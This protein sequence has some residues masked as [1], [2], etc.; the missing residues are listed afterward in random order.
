MT[1]PVYE[2]PEAEDGPTGDGLADDGRPVLEGAGDGS[3]PVEDIEAVS[4]AESEALAEAAETGEAVEVVAQRSEQGEVWAQPDGTLEGRSFV[5]PQW[6]R[7]DG[8]WVR[9]DTTLREADGVVVPVAST[10]DVEFSA[11]GDG[12]LVRIDRMGRVVELTWPE[13][14][15]SPG[16]D[17]DTATYSE[18]L[19]G[20]DLQMTAT[21]DGY[22]SY[23]VVKTP[24]AATSPELAEIRFSLETQGLDVSETEDGG[25][26]ARDQG[27]AGVVFA[28]PPAAM[29]DTVAEEPDQAGGESA[30]ATSLRTS[31]SGAGSADTAADAA[32]EHGD[33]DTF[34]E[35]GV[36][37]SAERDRL[38]LIPDQGLLNDPE[39]TFPVVIDPQWHTPK[40]GAWASPNKSYPDNMGWKFNGKS[41]QGLGTCTGWSDCPGGSTYR[42]MYQFDVSRFKGTRI[43]SAEFVVKNTH[44]AVCSNHRV[45]LWRVGAINSSNTSW[46]KTSNSTF[47]KEL[48]AHDSFH[49]GGNQSTCN[50]A[51]DAE[52]GIRDTVQ[53]FAD[54]RWGRL[55]LGMRAYSETNKSYWKKFSRNG[56]V[57]VKYNRAPNRI[58]ATQ[59]SMNPGGSCAKSGDAP[60]IRQIDKLVASQATD[61]DGDRLQVRFTITD[62]NNNQVWTSGLVPSSSKANGSAFSVQVPK[63]E[64]PENKLLR[65]AVRVWDGHDTSKWSYAD[66]GWRCHFVYDTSRPKEPTIT[67]ARWP[68]SDPE[69]PEDP[70]LD[71][72]G[73]SGGF[74][75]STTSGDVVKYRYE[76]NAQP[77]GSSREVTAAQAGFHL[78]PSEPGVYTI[79]AQALDAAGN[80]STTATYQVR[81][82]SGR[83]PVSMWGFDGA[84]ADSPLTLSGDAHV[85]SMPAGERV[86]GDALLLD[87]AGDSG[88]AP[89]SER[90]ATTYSFA[91]EAWAYLD[92]KTPGQAVVVSQAGP[93][94]M[95]YK[96]YYTGS[97]DG[98][99]DRWAF[100][101]YTSDLA[102]IGVG[103]DVPVR[104]GRWTHLVGVHNSMTNQL[105]IYVDGV[106][107][108]PRS[109]SDPVSELGPVTIGAGRYSAT[110]NPT[111]FWPGRVDGVNLYD[112]MVPVGEAAALAYA[113][114]SVAARWSFEPTTVDPTASP[115]TVASEVDTTGGQG[116]SLTLSA[117]AGLN[118]EWWVDEQALV[119]DGVD[120]Y[121]ATSSVPLDTSNSF[122]LTG[123]AQA[124]GEL[125]GSATVAA[126]NG[127]SESAVLVEAEPGIPDAEGEPAGVTWRLI[128]RDADGS[129]AT[130]AEAVDTSELS[131]TDWTHLAVVYDAARRTARLVVNGN[132]ADVNPMIENVDV[133][134]ASASVSVGRG[135]SAGAWGGYWPGQVDDVWLFNGTLSDAQINQFLHTQFGM[136]TEVPGGAE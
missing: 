41:T 36:E 85:A 57:R 119:L 50:S 76:V 22:A 48:I 122:T 116:P 23:F 118:Q 68:A 125:D 111:S 99:S 30:E 135:R 127:S 71:G 45:D 66:S 90:V 107:S 67:S 110:A 72:V 92:T 124:A 134:S 69:N 9:V 74:D 43:L 40:A 112:R 6:T 106:P 28:A 2:G 49:Y 93:D 20:V 87:G 62:T 132:D 89:S 133:F 5:V 104:T 26:E 32:G 75:F 55:T 105:L 113:R 31:A 56:Y 4:Q 100:G 126:I 17:G 34:A 91:V 101:R 96:L 42:L 84:A 18:V 24:E 114:P 7:A 98:R 19:D 103:S 95:D 131:A 13:P 39:T 61:P 21:E 60:R 3:Q 14:L 37:V 82:G 115:V 8:D 128:M 73:Q 46:N 52:F 108:T 1:D 25:L 70:W 51:A 29:W 58:K 130:V 83:P 16:L 53:Q 136:P 94:Y 15:P 47:W 80:K 12:P 27:A 10:V 121:A 78:M 79:N 102:I 33:P 120:G 129:S 11:G 117:G 81:I 54:N 38:T 59:L 35:V 86:D 63:A 123:W 97:A 109:F 64:I 44:S 88:M 65:W 77:T